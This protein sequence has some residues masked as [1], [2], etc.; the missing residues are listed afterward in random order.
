MRNKLPMAE[1]KP[2]IELTLA[3][4]D[5]PT[6]MGKRELLR[7]F[8]V[9]VGLLQAGDSRDLMPKILDVLMGE[10]E[11][12]TLEQIM[13]KLPKAAPSGVRRHLRRM[14]ELRIVERHKKRYRLAEGES[15]EF[16]VKYLLKRYIDEEIFFRIEEYAEA[17]EGVYK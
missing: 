12:Q 16:I 14:M 4:Y 13:K 8:C 11:P 2:L 9:S 17:L 3:K 7:R 10:R 15:L 5:K 6:S 1:E